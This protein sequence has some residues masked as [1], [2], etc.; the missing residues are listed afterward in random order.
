M[1][2]RYQRAMHDALWGRAAW[3]LRDWVKRSIRTLKRESRN[4]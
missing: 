1:N 3:L 4:A 2:R